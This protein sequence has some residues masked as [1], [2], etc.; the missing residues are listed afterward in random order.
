[1]H[2]TKRALDFKCGSGKRKQRRRTKEKREK[3][4]RDDQYHTN[5]TN[6]L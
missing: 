1:M 6:F 5:A 3:I 4:K 2:F